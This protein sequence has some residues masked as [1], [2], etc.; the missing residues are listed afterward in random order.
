[1][2]G[3]ATFRGKPSEVEKPKPEVSK[4]ETPPLQQVF[5]NFIAVVSQEGDTFSSLASKYLKDPSMDWFIAEFNEMET[6]TPGQPLIIP[7]KPN[8][9]GGLTSKGYQT[10]PFLVIIISHLTGRND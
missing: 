4:V 5:P 8:Q 7:L 6:L 1:L 10:V 3:C 2:G 9:R